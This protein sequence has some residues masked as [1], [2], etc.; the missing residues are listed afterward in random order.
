[1]PEGGFVPGPIPGLYAHQGGGVTA[2][3]VPTYK[4]RNPL[5]TE[6]A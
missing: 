1:M 5:A 6:V 4:G 3:V 2:W